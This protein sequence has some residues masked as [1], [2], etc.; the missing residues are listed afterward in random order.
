MDRKEITAGSRIGAMLLDHIVMCFIIA[1]LALPIMSL[2]F[3]SAFGENP[4]NAKDSFHWM[5]LITIIGMSL[6]LNK[7][8]IQGK[9]IAKRALKQEVIDIKTEQVASSLKCL[10][11]N[12]TIILWPIEVIAVL[13]N[14]SR[15]LGDLIAGTRVDYITG[16]RESRPKVDFKN[17]LI[18]LLLGFLIILIPSL[19]FFDK[20]GNGASDKPDYVE[21]SY[22]K[23]LSSAMEQHLDSVM[24]EYLLDVNIR[25]YDTVTND[26]LKY[27]SANFLLKQ[28]FME[29]DI[30]FKLIKKEIF[31]SM[32]E[33]VPKNE[34][35][36]F[37]KFMYDGKTTKQST[38]RTYDWRK[39]K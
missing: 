22:D 20:L 12:I 28:N 13:I 39:I 8:I 14:P 34:F 23:G 4:T 31:N 36:L 6:Y 21:T 16:E 33:I 19:F 27:I 11:R 29:N 37:G 30:N 38:W 2:E 5:M 10:I 7:D 26:S 18:S 9:S 17:L 25:V 32:F 1:I 3:K 24:S 35:I 15:R